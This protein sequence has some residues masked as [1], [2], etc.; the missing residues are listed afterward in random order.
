MWVTPSHTALG[1]TIGA[2]GMLGESEW[3]GGLRRGGGGICH[4]VS[5][6]SVYLSSDLRPTVAVELRG[7][8]TLLWKWHLLE[9]ASQKESEDGKPLPSLPFGSPFCS[10]VPLPS[11][12]R[13]DPGKVT[14]LPWAS[15]YSSANRDNKTHIFQIF[16][17]LE[18]INRLLNKCLLNDHNRPALII[19]ARYTG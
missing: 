2:Q 14:K 6:G 17:G 1:H 10:A 13:D 4:Y 8:S 19:L 3:G 16:R 7:A 15:V 12:E 9:K 5:A 11:L 18:E